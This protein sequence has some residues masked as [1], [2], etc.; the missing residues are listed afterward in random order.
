MQ[1]L[2]LLRL[3]FVLSL[4]VDDHRD[5]RDGAR[6]RARACRVDPAPDRRHALHRRRPPIVSRNWKVQRRSGSLRQKQNA[7]RVK[8]ASNVKLKLVSTLHTF[9]AFPREH[10]R[11]VRFNQCWL[12]AMQLPSLS[13]NSATKPF[14]PIS[15]LGEAGHARYVEFGRHTLS[16]I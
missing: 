14:S 16:R 8:K 10:E 4:T 11:C 6:H 3:K 15:V 7:R 9:H 2:I 1:A 13:S 5:R 12:S